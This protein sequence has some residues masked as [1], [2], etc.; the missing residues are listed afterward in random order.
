MDVAVA[1]GVAKKR[2][3]V[4]NDENIE[5]N[6]HHNSAEKNEGRSDECLH[7]PH[8]EFRPRLKQVLSESRDSA[9]AQFPPGL[10][11]PCP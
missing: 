6:Q 3:R 4:A 5:S 11:G 9:D 10:Y 8:I 7:L 2:M 1:D